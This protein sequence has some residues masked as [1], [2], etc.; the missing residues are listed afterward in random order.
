MA[1]RSFATPPERMSLLSSE[2]AFKGQ[3]LLRCLFATDPR[4]DRTFH[5]LWATEFASARERGTAYSHSNQDII[6][7]VFLPSRCLFRCSTWARLQALRVANLIHHRR[8]VAPTEQR[9]N[10]QFLVRSEHPPSLAYC[11]L[12]TSEISRIVLV[13]SL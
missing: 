4:L 11:R 13:P 10:L 2:S 8:G 7:R 1:A 3:W 6:C 9:Q 12:D 5:P